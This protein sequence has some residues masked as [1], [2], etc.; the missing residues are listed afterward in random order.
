MPPEYHRERHI[1][2]VSQV[3]LGMMRIHAHI[4]HSNK[5]CNHSRA[6]MKPWSQLRQ[7]QIYELSRVLFYP[8]IS[9]T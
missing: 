2:A 1:F 9:P 5:A 3:A 8:E 4:M 7:R 6:N